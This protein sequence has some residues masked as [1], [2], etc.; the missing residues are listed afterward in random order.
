MEEFFI[1]FFFFFFLDRKTQFVNIATPST[2]NTVLGKNP[3]KR[4]C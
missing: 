1:F 3:K 4:H 2:E